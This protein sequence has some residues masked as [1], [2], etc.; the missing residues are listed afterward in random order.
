M[1]TPPAPLRSAHISSNNKPAVLRMNQPM[2][3]NQPS[4]TNKL[5]RSLAYKAFDILREISVTIDGDY[6]LLTAV[7]GFLAVG[8]FAA[9]KMLFLVRSS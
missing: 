9:K 1:Q 7:H 2:V 6:W 4:S 5:Y 3:D 8:Q